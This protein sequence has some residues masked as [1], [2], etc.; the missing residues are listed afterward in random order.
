MLYNSSDNLKAATSE[1]DYLASLLHTDLQLYI[2]NIKT[3][4]HLLKIKEL[5]LPLTLN[6][7]ED[8]NSHICSP[9]TR[10]TTYANKELTALKSPFLKKSLT[11]MIGILAAILKAGK[12]DQL[13]IVNN[14]LLSTPL[15]P[16][17]DSITIEKMTS[18]LI[19][20]FPQ[21]ALLFP[22]LNYFTN[23]TLIK[24]LKQKGYQLVPSGEI[25][26]LDGNLKQKTKQIVQDQALLK[27]S[28]YQI[29]PHSEIIEEDYDRMAQLYHSLYIKKYSPC[30]PQYTPSLIK[31]WHQK[32]ILHF[33][34][35]RRKEGDLVGFIAYFQRDGVIAA[36]LLGYDL[37]F[38]T[39][40]GLYR[41]LAALI[42]K[43]T[44]ENKWIFNMGAGASDFKK[45]RGGVGYI[46]Y[47][48]VYA[49]HLALKRNAAWKVL[50]SAMSGIGVPILRHYK[51]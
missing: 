28:S 25:F 34:G 31:L 12:I 48:L 45:L 47:S 40:E 44:Y 41:Q 32:N 46:E 38:P 26:I 43:K 35:L 6:D 18:F 1:D 8:N 42:I 49:K 39:K 50:G 19:K 16:S 22:A 10:Y 51:F 30:N 20:A 5:L 37:S 23:S 14:W 2:S 27:K 33:Q 3:Q 9:F 15:Y 24:N 21:H 36:P 17:L 29:V 7:T 11:F 13:A 4:L